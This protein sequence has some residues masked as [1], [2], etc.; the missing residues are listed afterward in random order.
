LQQIINDNPFLRRIRL[1]GTTVFCATWALMFALYFPAARAGFVADFT[2]WLDQVQNHTF[3]EH[4][5]RTNYEVRSFYQ[6]T[7]FVTYVFFKLFGTNAWLWHLLFITLHSINAVLLYLLSA[8]LLSDAGVQKGNRI[9]FVGVLLFSISP[10]ISEVIVWEPSFH[11]LQGLI[12]ILLILGC[13]QRYIHTGN[14]KY[15]WWACAVYLLST[16]SLEIFYITPWLVLTLALF[17][18]YQSGSN[19]K[20]IGNTLRYFVVPMLV[21]FAGRLLLFRV[22]Y[23]SWVSRIGAGAVTTLQLDSFGKPAKYLFHLLFLGR[24]FPHDI[25]QK[26][27]AACDSMAG[28]IIFYSLVVIVLAY[29]LLRFRNMGGRAKA[30]SLLFVWMGITLLLLIPLWFQDLLLVLNDRY[31]YFTD[32]FFYMLVAILA[33]YIT[34]KFLQIALLAIFALANLR[35]AIQVNRY[36]WKSEKII[37]GLLRNIP[38]EKERTIILL[39]I[40]QNMHG[41]AMIGAEKTS[42]YKLMHDQLLPGKKIQTTVYDALAYNMETPAD[43]AHV[44]VLSDSTIKVTLNQWGTWWWFETKGAYSYETGD[45]RLNLTDPGH[46][47][48]LILKKPASQYL[49]LYQVGDTWKAVDMGNKNE[50]G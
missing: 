8:H 15:A 33:S 11:F 35:F 18:R 9:S 49:L 46:E 37:S 44:N 30:A 10:Y 14:T 13:A 21:L 23:G 26:V 24:F 22:V 6:L 20:N 4:I 41:I 32:A 27:Y 19:K 12:F 34:L 43:G 25:K 5:N 39:N 50:Q 31:T 42:E 29:I 2:G 36:W 7:Q 48:I 17:Y 28:I 3:W 16:F 38:E 1:N 45:Y 47:Y 40:P